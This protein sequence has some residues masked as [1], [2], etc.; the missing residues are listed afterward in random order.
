MQI[1]IKNLMLNFI[2]IINANRTLLYFLKSVRGLFTLMLH[3][4]SRVDNCGAICMFHLTNFFQ[5]R[6]NVL[7]FLW[8]CIWTWKCSYIIDL[9]TVVCSGSLFVQV[10]CSVQSAR[11]LQLRSLKLFFDQQTRKL[12]WSATCTIGVTIYIHTS[13]NTQINIV[14]VVLLVESF[15]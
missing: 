11:V 7:L 2:A 8:Y 9:A 6:R 3:G 10:N 13:G 15:I 14:N 4:L 12:Q 5:K 1:F